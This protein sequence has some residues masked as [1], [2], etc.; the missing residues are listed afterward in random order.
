MHFDW[1]G[2]V[3]HMVPTDAYF[4]HIA[5]LAGLEVIQINTP[6]S[7]RVGSSIIQSS[8]RVGKVADTHRL[9]ESV[10]ELRKH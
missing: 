8:V 1:F 9:Y 2:C 7:N 5:A 6:R 3:R 4:G 10:I